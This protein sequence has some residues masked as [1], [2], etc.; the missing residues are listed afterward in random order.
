LLRYL[1]VAH[2]GRGRGRW[3]EGE[4]PP[5]WQQPVAD[6]VAGERELLHA[7]WQRLRTA[8]LAGGEV[9]AADPALRAALARAAAQ[10][11]DELYPGCVPA[12]LAER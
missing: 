6:A 5:S 2:F 1:A 11:L 8:G 9:P 10:V 4:S 12:D 7:A 3:V